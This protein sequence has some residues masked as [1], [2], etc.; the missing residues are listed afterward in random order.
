MLNQPLH[1]FH[2]LLQP[3]EAK[4]ADEILKERF[5]DVGRNPEA[6]SAIKYVG[7]KTLSDNTNFKQLF[8]TVIELTN[9]TSVR[10][11][12]PIGVVYDVLNVRVYLCISHANFKQTKM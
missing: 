7:T 1:N 5:A 12:R 6:F 9:D 11:R 10:S 2:N 4:S 3:G 8:E